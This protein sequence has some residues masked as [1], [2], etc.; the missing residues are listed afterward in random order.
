MSELK[1]F[2]WVFT[3]KMK[4]VTKIE[5]KPKPVVFCRDCEEYIEWQDGTRI[6]GRL[7]SYYGDTSPDDF[8]SRGKAKGCAVIED[9]Y[10]ARKKITVVMQDKG[11]VSGDD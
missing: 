7:G 4:D 2:G 11:D 5:V 3:P 8:C 9:Y 1:P 6:C 10:E